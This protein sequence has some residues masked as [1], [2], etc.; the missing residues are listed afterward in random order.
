[1]KRQNKVFMKGLVRAYNEANA[2][3]KEAALNAWFKHYAPSNQSFGKTI[4][5]KQT[6][7]ASFNQINQRVHNPWFD[8]TKETLAHRKLRL[9]GAGLSLLGLRNPLRVEQPVK[10]ENKK[11][12]KTFLT[13]KEL[14]KQ[15]GKKRK[16]TK[17]ASVPATPKRDVVKP[18][19]NNNKPNLSRNTTAAKVVAKVKTLNGDVVTVDLPTKPTLN[20]VLQSKKNFLNIIQTRKLIKKLTRWGISNIEEAMSL[21]HTTSFTN[22]LELGG[23]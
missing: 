21:I 19:Q 2:I 12:Q 7:N 23:A 9:S 6:V 10:E 14:R 3:K 8:E 5:G 13:P 11:Q 15:N 1:M 22:Q 18:K 20:E 17:K 4:G 16:G